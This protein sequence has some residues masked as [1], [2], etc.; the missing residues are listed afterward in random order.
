VDTL[1]SSAPFYQWS[2]ANFEG[3]KVLTSRRNANIPHN[4]HI[5]RPAPPP[6]NT[7]HAGHRHLRFRLHLH[8]HVTRKGLLHPPHPS[9]IPNSTSPT[10]PKIKILANIQDISSMVA[11]CCN[12]SL[13]LPYFSFSLPILLIFIIYERL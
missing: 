11:W 3:E 12:S 7:R 5:P 1:P 10:V 13:L 8:S 2:V 9:S 6:A 4:Q